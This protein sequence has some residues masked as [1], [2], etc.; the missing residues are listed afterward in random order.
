MR[1]EPTTPNRRRM[2]TL[3]LVYSRPLISMI[4]HSRFRGALKEVRHDRRR[5]YQCDLGRGVGLARTSAV[6]N[7]GGN[8]GFPGHEQ[9]LIAARWTIEPAQHC[10]PRVPCGLFAVPIFRR[11]CERTLRA[12]S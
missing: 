10:E 3:T 7:Y 8:G 1:A 11:S 12:N 4:R 9:H 6:G 5:R 2:T